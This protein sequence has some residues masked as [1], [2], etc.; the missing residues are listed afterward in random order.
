MRCGQ[1]AGRLHRHASQRVRAARQTVE[2]GLYFHGE[3]G[4]VLAHTQEKVE[5]QLAAEAAAA[6][7]RADFDALVERVQARKLKKGDVPRLQSVEDVALMAANASAVMKGAGLAA[8]P[9]QAQQLLL[10]LG[11]WADDFNPW[12]QRFRVAMDPPEG[13]VPKPDANV[14]VERTDLTHLEAWAIDQVSLFPAP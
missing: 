9:E 2:D 5:A 3:P 14:P 4:E 7:E 11:I 10:D 1:E 13:K 6:A 12:P 8:T